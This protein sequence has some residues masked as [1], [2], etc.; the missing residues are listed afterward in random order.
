MRNTRKKT[1]IGCA[2]VLAVLLGSGAVALGQDASHAASGYFAGQTNAIDCS[3]AYP[4]GKTLWS[5]AWKPVLPDGWILLTNSA[6][7]WGDGS[8]VANTNNGA[9]EIAFTGDLTN[10]PVVFH[11]T[12]FAPAGETGTK[13]LRA[14]AAHW[15]NGDDNPTTEQ[16]QPDPLPLPEL[17]TLT[18]VSD[19]GTGTPPAGTY[20]NIYGTML[21]NSV[22]ALD[23]QG[24]TQYVAAGGAVAGNGYLQNSLTNITLTLTNDATLTWAWQTQYRLTLATNGNGTLD[25]ASGGWY[26]AGSNVAVTVTA[27]PHNHFT[28]WSGDTNGCTWAGNVLTAAMTQARSIVANFTLDQQT[29]NVI[30]A[31]NGETPGTQTVDYGTPVSQWL[32]NSPVAN[33]ATQYVAAGGAVAGNDYLQNSLTNITLTLTND[34][35]LTWA[36]QTQYQLV[37]NVTNGTVNTSNGWVTADTALSITSTPSQYYHFD[38]WSGDTNG[39]TMSSN[40]IN[41]SMTMPLTLQATCAAN[42]ATNGTP[43]WW[44]ASYG[45]TNRAWD[46]EA[47]DDQ[48]HDGALTWQEWQADTNPT[49]ALSVLRCTRIQCTNGMVRVDWQ[50]GRQALQKLQYRTSLTDTGTS[51][52]AI[53]TNFPPTEITNSFGFNSFTNR[54]FFRIKAER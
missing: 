34:A 20:T 27:T 51:W 47:M 23:T 10:N 6:A 5:L 16:V 32:T 2:V 17:H 44:L 45:L 42:L 26:D 48:D 21:T 37:V 24:A 41:I 49:N 18:I 39:A 40:T 50:G 53:Y 38:S 8:P 14:Q 31:H 15:F 30:S 28:G 25:V 3:F 54:C 46:T 52:T 7:A 11:Y 4:A 1:T 22:S 13:S 35:T 36:W 29:L 43:E 12:V 19:H 33:G 9:N